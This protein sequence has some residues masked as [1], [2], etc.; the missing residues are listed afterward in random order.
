VSSGSKKEGV[1]DVSDSVLTLKGTTLD[2]NRF[3]FRQG[4]PVGPHDIQRG[5]GL[6]SASL[7]SYHL[8]KLLEAGLV[9]ETQEGYVVDKM[10]FENSIRI[11]RLLIPA[12][13][14][15]VAFF[16]TA[17]ATLLTILRPPVI[18]ASYYFSI[19][20]LFVGLALVAFEAKRTVSKKV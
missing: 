14:S 11:R 6:G 15:Y 9:R 18:Y 2:V 13:A 5:L 4:R 12:Q 16:A 7:A 1:S 20:V 19:I 17:I 3:I 8:S 10:V